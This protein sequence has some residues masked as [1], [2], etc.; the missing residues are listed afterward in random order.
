MCQ[1][2]LIRRASWGSSWGSACVFWD[3]S[4]GSH[5]I[6]NP[7]EHKGV[8]LLGKTSPAQLWWS[9][10]RRPPAW[11]APCLVIQRKGPP[12]SPEPAGKAGA[13]KSGGEGG[14]QHPAHTGRAD[15][16]ED[17]V[18][19][20]A[21]AQHSHSVPAPYAPRT[22]AKDQGV[23]RD[24]PARADAVE[25]SENGAMWRERGGSEDHMPDD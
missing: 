24:G 10:K 16:G 13:A 7:S 22:R 8:L 6:P 17:A 14:A 18:Q 1:A 19:S 12:R 4:L 23:G 20:R 15:E 2:A 25:R 11:A 9:V 21:A 3:L 5:E